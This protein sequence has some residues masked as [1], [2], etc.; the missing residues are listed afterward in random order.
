MRI[1]SASDQTRS[2][3]TADA[4]DRPEFRRLSFVEPAT[5]LLPLSLR[6]DRAGDGGSES[7]ASDLGAGFAS[8][9]S[10]P[11]SAQDSS[12]SRVSDQRKLIPKTTAHSS[13]LRT[14]KRSGKWAGGVATASSACRIA[15]AE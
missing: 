4:I 3:G 13:T 9:P 10:P 6:T 2:S 8:A 7:E 5:D 12:A 15:M 14:T 11:T 1:D